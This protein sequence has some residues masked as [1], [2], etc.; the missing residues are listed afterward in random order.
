MQKSNENKELFQIYWRLDTYI[1]LLKKA[2]SE[3]SNHDELTV[4]V[5]G[6]EAQV[7]KLEPLIEDNILE[8]INLFEKKMQDSQEISTPARISSPIKEEELNRYNEAKFKLK[9]GNYAEAREVFNKFLNDFPRSLVADTAQFWVAES[10]YREGTYER[11]IVEYQKVIRNYPKAGSVPGTILKQAMAFQLLEENE[12]ARFLYQKV[13][14]KYPKT[15]Y[16]TKA[17]DVLNRLKV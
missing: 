14:K 17:R 13:I 4:L 7:R 6:L 1:S 16:F 15:E 11:A 8:K 10:Y 12:T 5:E 9:K 3:D 2:L